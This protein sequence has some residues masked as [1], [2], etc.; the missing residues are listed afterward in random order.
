[1]AYNPFGLLYLNG[2]PGVIRTPD[3]LIRSQSLYPAELRAHKKSSAT[4]GIAQQLTNHCQINRLCAQAQSAV[5]ELPRREP[6]AI[7]WLFPQGK[8]TLVTAGNHM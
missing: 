7:K 6:I 8:A 3:L 5:S 1:M 2:A 4:S